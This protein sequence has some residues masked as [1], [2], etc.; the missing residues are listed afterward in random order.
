MRFILLEKGISLLVLPKLIEASQ[1]KQF[2][3]EVIIVMRR[4][5]QLVECVGD[6][7]LFEPIIGVC[8]ATEE[9]GFGFLDE[10]VINWVKVSKE[11]SSVDILLLESPISNN[12][13]AEFG[14]F[15]FL[16]EP[17]W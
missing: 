12:I 15:E 3:T 6:S 9:C 1:L 4:A 7:I 13:E 17:W 5:Q 14:I 16:D 8:S 11:I 10:R 2:L